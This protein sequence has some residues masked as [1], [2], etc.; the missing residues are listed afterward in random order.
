MNKHPSKDIIGTKGTELKGKCIVLC[1]TG[2]VAA[3]ESPRIARSLMRHGAEV[4]TVMS[5]MAQK[6]IHPYIMEWATGNAVTTELTGKIEHIGL[7]GDQPERADLILVAP[8]TANTISKIACGIDDTSVTSLI[9]TAFGAHIPMIIVP[10]MHASMYRHPILIEN[11]KKLQTLG[12][13]FVG[14]RIVEGKAKIARTKDVIAAVIRRLT[15]V[16]DLAGLRLL[17][18]AGPTAEHID[19]IRIMTNRSSGKMGVAVAE[20]A[21]SRG[22]EVTLVYGLGT[23]AP[24]ARANV[25]SVE[26]TDQMHDT[27]VFELKSKKYDAVVATAAAADWKLTKP[28]ARKVSTHGLNSLSLELKPTRKI[29]DYVKKASCNTFLVAFRAEYRLPRKDL[30]ASAFKRLI[31]AKADLIVVND[32]SKKGAGFGTETNEVLIIDKKRKVIH[33]PMSPKRDVARRILDA[34]KAGIKTNHA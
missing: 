13:E 12:L 34:T 23:A 19:P 21:L 28:F 7:A 25:I 15:I 27:V 16:Q 11:I 20:E 10:A 14:P 5:P 33:V 8:A 1:I 17:V 24:P 31:E 32:V 4:L 2:S 26:T 9:S 18:T 3:T 29:I 6:I 30:I 22:A